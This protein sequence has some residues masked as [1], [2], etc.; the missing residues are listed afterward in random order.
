[1]RSSLSHTL[2]LHVCVLRGAVGVATCYTEG[3][4]GKGLCVGTRDCSHPKRWVHSRI[5]LRIN[6]EA[7]VA[8][9]RNPSQS[10]L[11]PERIYWLI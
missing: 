7:L 11:G 6:Q 4:E 5:G 2:R 10:G 9:D 8:G 1:M 3:Q